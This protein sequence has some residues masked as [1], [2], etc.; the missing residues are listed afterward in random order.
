MREYSLGTLIEIDATLAPEHVAMMVCAGMGVSLRR[1]HRIYRQG[2]PAEDIWFLVS[3]RA[4]SVLISQRGDETLLRL[5][6]A[7]SLL[8]LTALGSRPVR[9]AEAIA[10]TDCELVRIPRP[11]FEALLTQDGGLA[12]RVIALLV[13]RM[14]DFHHRVGDFV[15]LS[16]EQ[17]LAR[18]LLSL[19]RPDP[20]ER[21]GATRRAVG[22]THQELANLTNARRPTVT[23]VLRRFAEAGCIAR[24]GR[25]VLIRDER[26]LA[27]F[28]GPAG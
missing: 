19:S 2:E 5:H 11:D 22:L 17:R 10:L 7:H 16:V 28:A 1:N 15:G 20:Q 4:K 8:G 13:D 3:G 23:A 12:R 24:D 9:D 6:L 26:R 25:T 21:P 27:D 14:R 18:A